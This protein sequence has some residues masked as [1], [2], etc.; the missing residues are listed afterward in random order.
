[1]TAPQARWIALALAVICCASAAPAQEQGALVRGTPAGAW[2]VLRD[3]EGYRV[4]YAADGKAFSPA[5]AT[6]RGRIRLNPEA[7]ILQGLLKKGP[8]GRR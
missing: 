1:M 4:A 2:L 8:R 7:E 3:A 6:L 5:S